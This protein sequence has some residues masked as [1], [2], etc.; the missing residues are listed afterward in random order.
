MFKQLDAK[1]DEAFY[2]CIDT[3]NNAINTEVVEESLSY[4][5]ATELLS[6]NFNNTISNNKIRVVLV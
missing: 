1:T 3:A 5:P 4:T 6:E 2:N